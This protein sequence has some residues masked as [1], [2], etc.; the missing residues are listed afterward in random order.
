LL[1]GRKRRE[2]LLLKQLLLLL[3]GKELSLGVQERGWET[4]W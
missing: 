3:L 4:W 1:R 2:L